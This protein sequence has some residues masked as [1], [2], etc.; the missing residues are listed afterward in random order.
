MS[1]LTDQPIDIRDWR[2]CPTD[3]LEGASVEFQGRVRREEGGV[4]ITCLE[5]ETYEPMAERVIARLVEQTRQRWPVH[6][7]CVSHRVGRIP[8]GHVALFV[9]VRAA[10]RREAFEACQFLIDEIK[11]E[12]P[13]WKTAI[14]SDGARLNA[15]CAHGHS[16]D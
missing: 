12:A 11:R 1:Y 4:P 8:V 6:E 3:G 9:G 10:H 7:V 16:S 5:Y 15:P 13:I 14:G 2:A